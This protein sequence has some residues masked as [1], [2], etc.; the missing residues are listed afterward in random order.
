V[1]DGQ[2]VNIDHGTT[3]LR[4]EVQSPVAAA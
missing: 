1:R 4:F 3:G 2:R